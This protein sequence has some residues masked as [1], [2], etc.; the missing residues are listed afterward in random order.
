MEMRVG[1]EQ[2]NWFRSSRFS[3]V[4]GKWFYQ[5][6]EGAIEGPFDSIEEG[7]RDLLVYLRHA[8]D[9]LFSRSA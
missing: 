3:C 8:S 1:E 5:T 7:E 9:E 6:R 4:N 2:K